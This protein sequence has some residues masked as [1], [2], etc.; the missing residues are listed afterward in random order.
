MARLPA[1]WCGVTGFKPSFGLVPVTGHFPRVGGR[2]DGRTVIGPMAPRVA[3]VT[4]ILAVI[5]GPDGIDPDCVPIGLGDPR[6]V[7][8]EDLRVAV[9]DEPGMWAPAPSTPAAVAQAEIALRIVGATIVDPISPHLD[10][11]FDITKRYWQRSEL[12]GS[13]C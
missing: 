6:S 3:D 1:A 13:Q 10:E 5:S 12:S 11:S 9:V 4:S 7:R 8:I 2:G